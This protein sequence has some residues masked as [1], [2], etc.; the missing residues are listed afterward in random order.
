MDHECP[1]KGSAEVMKDSSVLRV[2]EESVKNLKLH[3]M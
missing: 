3:Y 2:Y 1:I